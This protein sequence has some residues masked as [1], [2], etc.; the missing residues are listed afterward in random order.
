MRYPR[1]YK[2]E[3]KVVKEFKEL[4]DDKAL[5]LVVM[6]YNIKH[7]D[8]LDSIARSIALDEYISL[9]A[10]RNSPYL[11]KSGIF[12]VQYKKVDLKKWDDRQLAGFFEDIRPKAERFYAGAGTE[13]SE[14]QNTERI[15]YLTAL[16]A[17]D[18]EL[19]RRDNTRDVIKV[20]GQI[21]FGVL[22]AALAIL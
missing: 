19:R 5:K 14:T 20:G 4:D 6:I 3:G 21:L 11:K 18:T 1:T 13:I 15:M 16:S 12:K 9:L 2:V 10:K 7:E 22:T 8:K 17:V